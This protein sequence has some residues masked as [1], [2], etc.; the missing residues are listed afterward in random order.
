MRQRTLVPPDPF[1][2]PR[3]LRLRVLQWRGRELGLSLLVTVPCGGGICAAAV[4]VVFEGGA[5]GS[6]GAVR[7]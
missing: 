4:V 6:D 5:W 1:A 7:G 3:A 2:G